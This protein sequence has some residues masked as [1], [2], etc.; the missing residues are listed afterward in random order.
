[1][2]GI[3]DRQKAH[4]FEPGQTYYFE[5]QFDMKQSNLFTG[6][7]K[8][9]ARVRPDGAEEVAQCQSVNSNGVFSLLSK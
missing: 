9:K 1:V 4:I 2:S 3:D 5:V 7:R 6:S 8:W